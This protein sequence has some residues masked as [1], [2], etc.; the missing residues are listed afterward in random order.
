MTIGVLQKHVMNEY[1]KQSLKIWALTE[2]FVGGGDF[3]D[4]W[5]LKYKEIRVSGAKLF[6]W[7]YIFYKYFCVIS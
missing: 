7:V 4:I 6:W 1:R 3:T 2:H 5:S